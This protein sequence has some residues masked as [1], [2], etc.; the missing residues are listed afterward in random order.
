[1]EVGPTT[2]LVVDDDPSL[3]LLC[4]VNLELDGYRVLDA[5]TLAEA[6]ALLDSE[7]VRVVLLD[8]HLGADDGRQ[9]ITHIRDTARDV[10]V[11]LFTGSSPA[12]LEPAE[13]VDALLAK[14]FSL[15]LLSSTVRRLAGP[16]IQVR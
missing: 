12:L 2:I 8:V 4:R 11:A 13:G 9:L 6:Q 7:H 15:D 10:R 14:P 1:M 16:G 3:R 5:S